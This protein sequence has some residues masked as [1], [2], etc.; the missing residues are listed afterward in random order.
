MAQEYVGITFSEI[1]LRGGRDCNKT[2]E[3][4]GRE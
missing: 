2:E 3:A 1:S 4:L